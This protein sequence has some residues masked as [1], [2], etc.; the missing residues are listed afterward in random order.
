[1]SAMGSW[2]EML[3]AP[4]LHPLPTQT[5]RQWNGLVWAGT[6]MAVVCPVYRP[7]IDCCCALLC[8]C[9]CFQA[10]F[11][12]LLARRG[13][14]SADEDA[15]LQELQ[16]YYK[17]EG[18]SAAAGGTSAGGQHPKPPADAPGAAGAGNNQP[19]ISAA[20]AAAESIVSTGNN[21]P[22]FAAAAASGAI[23]DSSSFGPAGSYDSVFESQRQALWVS[24]ICSLV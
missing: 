6:L 1:M 23:A 14:L 2:V 15:R 24:G 12:R 13:A 21:Q 8:C 19:G 16:Q 20:A 18:S 9:C 5:K 4:P 17:L 7:H 10:E 22:H 3:P 11:G